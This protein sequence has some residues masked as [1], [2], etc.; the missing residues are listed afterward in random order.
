MSTF[1]T[2]LGRIVGGSLSSP[3]TEDYQ[4]NNLDK[5]KYLVMLAIPKTDP[6]LAAIVAHVKEV[7]KV[8]YAA[9]PGQSDRPDFAWKMIDGDSEVPNRKGDRPCTKE[10]YK[11][12]VV[13]VF[14]TTWSFQVCGPELEL[15]D[16]ST[17]SRGDYVEICGEAVSGFLPSGF[18]REI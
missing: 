4:G 8:G 7:G 2:P 15:I 3:Q 14:E 16:A 1:N 13:F 11:G 10:G 9:K 5:P 18:L 17:V 6:G 12:H